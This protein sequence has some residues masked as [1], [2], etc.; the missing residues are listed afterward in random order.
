MEAFSASNRKVDIVFGLRIYN[1]FK[2]I[3]G[4]ILGGYKFLLTI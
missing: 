4:V 3:L 1:K 2:V